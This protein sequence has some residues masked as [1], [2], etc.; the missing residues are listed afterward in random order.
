MLRTSKASAR[1]NSL[2]KARRWSCNHA[3]TSVRCRCFLCRAATNFSRSHKSRSTTCATDFSQLPR[4]RRDLRNLR[5]QCP[6]AWVSRVCSI[7]S[8]TSFVR[9]EPTTK[10]SATSR[11]AMVMRRCA[12][13]GKTSRPTFTN[14]W[15]TLCSSTTRTAQAFSAPTAINGRMQGSSRIMSSDRSRDSH[16]VT[17]MAWNSMAQMRSR[18]HLQDSSG[19]THSHTTRRSVCSVSLR[20]RVSTG[21][22]AHARTRS[23]RAIA[24]R[25]S[26]LAMVRSSR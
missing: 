17:P 25:I 10:C 13:L 21:K 12:S 6:S 1:L 19:T 7:M 9:I 20:S 14:S 16:A 22:I 26:R 15:T 5:A 4:S 23:R 3:S 2:Q 11:K 8:S 18:I 24:G